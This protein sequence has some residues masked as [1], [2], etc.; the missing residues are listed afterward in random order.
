L[1][2]SL[3]ALF[4][5]RIPRNNNNNQSSITT[6]SHMA[7]EEEAEAEVAEEE[8]TMDLIAQRLIEATLHILPCNKCEHIRKVLLV[9]F[10]LSDSVCCC[11]A[12]I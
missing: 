7:A 4:S 10:S 1:K 11:V 2:L 12:V 6:E 9:F 3:R 8:D 5:E